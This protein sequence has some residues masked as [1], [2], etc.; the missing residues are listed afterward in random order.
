MEDCVTYYF[1]NAFKLTAFCLVLLLAIVCFGAFVV[2]VDVDDG[3][4]AGLATVEPDPSS[5]VKFRR[6][7]AGLGLEL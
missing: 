2:S 6:A 1:A 3:A 4:A 5:A 7:N